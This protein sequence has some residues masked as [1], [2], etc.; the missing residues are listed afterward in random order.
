MR[1]YQAPNLAFYKMKGLV[2]VF[3]DAKA[4]AEANHLDAE[5]VVARCGSLF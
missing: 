2:K 3:P 1:T 5:R 4:F